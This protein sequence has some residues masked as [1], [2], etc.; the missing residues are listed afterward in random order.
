MPVG[1]ACTLIATMTGMKYAVP[2]GRAT[3]HEILVYPSG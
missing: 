3:G 1:S 2:L